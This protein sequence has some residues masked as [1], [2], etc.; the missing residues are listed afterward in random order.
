MLVNEAQIPSPRVSLSRRIVSASYVMPQG[1]NEVIL[2]AWDQEGRLMSADT[3]VWAG[4]RQL[5]ID[6]VDGVGQPLEGAAVTVQLANQRSVQVTAQAQ[7]G[8]AQFVNLPQES[9]AVAGQ[10]PDSRRGELTVGPE[11]QRAILVLR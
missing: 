6:V 11:E 1:L 2:R 3:L 5:V 9:I 7:G 8:V 10:H 4:D